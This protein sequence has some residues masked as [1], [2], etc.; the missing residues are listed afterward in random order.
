MTGRRSTERDPFTSPIVIVHE[1]AAQCGH[2]T[3]QSLEAAEI[4]NRL[5]EETNQRTSSLAGA[6]KA[7]NNGLETCSATAASIQTETRDALKNMSD[8]LDRDFNAL[9]EIISNKS[10]DTKKILTTIVEIGHQIKILSINARIEAARAGE[11]G[12]GFAVVANEVGRLAETTMGHAKEAEVLL[13]FADVESQIDNAGERFRNAV[14]EVRKTSDDSLG[15]VS[16]TVNEMA[17]NLGDVA[18]NN[19][20]IDEL[21]DM[22]RTAGRRLRARLGWA[23]QEL[24]DI[25]SATVNAKD[26]HDPLLQVA[27][28]WNLA[29]VRDR[30]DEIRT[31]GVLRVGVEPGFVGLSFR[32]RPREEL[33]GLDVDYARAYAQ[34]IGVTCE[35]VEY[36]WDALTGLLHVGIKQGEQPVDVIWSALPPNASYRK[37]AYSE[38]YTYLPF[39]LARRAG[40]TRVRKLG[41]LDGKVLGVINDP[42][43]FEVLEAAGVRWSANKGKPNGKI[44]IANLVAYSD[45]G[46]IHDCLAEGKVDGFCV[47]LPIYHWACSNPSSPWFGKIEIMPGNLSSKLYYYT[48]AVAASPASASLLKSINSFIRSFRSSARCHQIE[49]QWQGRVHE[50]AHG[51][52]DEPGHLLGE[53]E[54]SASISYG[55]AC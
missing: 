13:N 20:V 2:L 47:D 39:V 51:Y 34:S 23:V 49:Q 9:M 18:D 54:L 52:R 27:R 5:I 15:R 10:A 19:K 53:A 50:G 26:A 37:V 28:R 6:L 32:R 1:A 36:P 46:R 43:A 41:D 17:V 24:D 8:A 31:R 16:T 42:G 55:Q 22:Q 40:D 30:L 25:A 44:F 33:M 14:A 45:Q 21:V 7:A 29:P 3:G 35:F 12:R 38:T 4:Q 11:A 48:V